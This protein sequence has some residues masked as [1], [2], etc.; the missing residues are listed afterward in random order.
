MCRAF[1]TS[2]GG[3]LSVAL[4]PELI[5]SGWA[6]GSVRAHPRASGGATVHVLWV[7]AGVHALTHSCGVTSIKLANRCGGCSCA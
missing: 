2:E 3:A 7:L 4:T 1:E 6:D 5:L